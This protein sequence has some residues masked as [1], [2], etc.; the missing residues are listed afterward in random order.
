MQINIQLVKK[1]KQNQRKKVNTKADVALKLN[2][3]RRKIMYKLVGLSRAL[4]VD[5]ERNR[6]GKIVMNRKRKII[7]V[8]FELLLIPFLTLMIFFLSTLTD[9]TGIFYGKLCLDISTKN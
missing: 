3:L 9:M 5:D 2:N 4:I 7:M 6:M 8:K 1:K